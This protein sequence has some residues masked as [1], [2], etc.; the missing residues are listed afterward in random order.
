MQ[1]YK[2]YFFCGQSYTFDT[3]LVL[4]FLLS[5]SGA[6]QPN[7]TVVFSDDPWSSDY[8]AELF[9]SWDGKCEVY[10]SQTYFLSKDDPVDFTVVI[11]FGCQVTIG[12][13]EVCKL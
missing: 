8:R 4:V 7:P 10:N 3:G 11:D 9:L 6:C 13:K 2:C 12:S 5:F 1:K